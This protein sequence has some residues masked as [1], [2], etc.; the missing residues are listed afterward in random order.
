LIDDL[1]VCHDKYYQLN[2]LPLIFG[3]IQDYN[4]EVD[5]RFIPVLIFKNA[6]L[7]LFQKLIEILRYYL[8]YVLTVQSTVHFNDKSYRFPFKILIFISLQ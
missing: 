2:Y 4:S 6:G 8:A 5:K 1:K 3:L 7:S